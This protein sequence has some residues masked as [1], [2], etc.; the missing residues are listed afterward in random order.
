METPV[1]CGEDCCEVC[2]ADNT[3]CCENEVCGEGEVATC[4]GD[5]ETCVNG[6][7]CATEN[8]CGE[9]E[10]AECCGEGEDCCKDTCCSVDEVCADETTGTCCPMDKPILCNGE[11]RE[12]MTPDESKCERLTEDGCDIESKCIDYEYNNEELECC[13]GQCVL[14]CDPSSG[15]IRNEETCECECPEGLALCNG[16]CCSEGQECCGG[17]CIGKCS[18]T[19]CER[20]DS[21]AQACVKDEANCGDCKDEWSGSGTVTVIDPVTGKYTTTSVDTC[22]ASASFKCL[23]TCYLK[24]TIPNEVFY[25][26]CVNGNAQ[27]TGTKYDY[28]CCETGKVVCG[29]SNAQVCC[30]ACNADN[31]GCCDKK[32]C[33]K[34]CCSMDEV[35][36]DEATGKCCPM[37]EPVLCGGDCCKA[38]DM[39]G[40]SCCDEERSCGGNCCSETQECKDGKT[41]CDIIDKSKCPNG[42]TM[43][44]SDGCEICKCAGDTSCPE[45][46]MLFKNYKKGIGACG[47]VC[48]MASAEN[49]G[50]PEKDYTSGYTVAGAVNGGCCAGYT[51]EQEYNSAWVGDTKGW[52]E[53]I[54]Q[55]SYAI[56]QKSDGTYYCAVNQ[57]VD[58][59]AY[60]GKVTNGITATYNGDQVCV[61]ESVP[62]VLSFCTTDF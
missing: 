54:H 24:E 18:S 50:D 46:Q 7:C 11:C 39:F 32:I 51:Y 14:P 52:I 57:N 4:C 13:K 34:A 59:I 1:K 56:E 6:T 43:I 12:K 27:A 21:S 9:G 10:N 45:G 55:F 48:C 41:C 60:N 47:E 49:M 3:G 36:A 15:T 16:V 28:E 25:G 23:G 40:K 38:C 17:K 44:A 53:L 31:T 19:A 33:G 5:E 42:E 8:K 35:C 58:N 22:T 2:N 30:D 29:P 26:D 20:C 61:Y 62:R 37:D